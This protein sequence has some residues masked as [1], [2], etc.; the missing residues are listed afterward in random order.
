MLTRLLLFFQFDAIQLFSLLL[1]LVLFAGLGATATMAMARGLRLSIRAQRLL[2]AC[3]VLALTGVVAWG[4]T[5]AGRPGQA[6]LVGEGGEQRLIVLHKSQRGRY[7]RT[8]YNELRYYELDGRLIGG[9][10]LGGE[11]ESGFHPID[12]S[13]AIWRSGDDVG[14]LEMQTGESVGT[15]DEATKRLGLGKVRLL[16]LNPAGVRVQLRDGSERNLGASELAPG[17]APAASVTPLVSFTGRRLR[18]DEKLFNARVLELGDRLSFAVH[19]DAAFDAEDRLL[20]AWRGSDLL[21][22]RSLEEVTDGREP[23]ALLER[24][25][26]LELLVWSWWSGVAL[27]P[28]ELPQG[29]HSSSTSLRN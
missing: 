12:G 17:V 8:I 4:T 5:F 6:W 22:R 2:A 13:L 21:M 20:S 9:R 25:E 28:L 18:V 1:A 10:S 15:L 29:Q 16:S 11:Y 14:V 26:G 27:V 19:D 23:F 24:G 7:V 3:A